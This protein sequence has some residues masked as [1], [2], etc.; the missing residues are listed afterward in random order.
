[1]SAPTDRVPRIHDAL[2][3]APD[4][5][6][7]RVLDPSGNEAGWLGDVGRWLVLRLD[8]V[9]SM[10]SLR[11]EFEEAFGEPLGEG[12]LEAILERLEAHGLL[13]TNERALWALRYLAEKGLQYR[14]VERERR[15]DGSRQETRRAGP[16]ERAEAWDH[17]V[18]LVNEAYLERALGVFRELA[19]QDPSDLR[20]Q[21]MV[22]HLEF[23]LAQESS[24]HL[25]TDRR[26]DDWEAFDQALRDMLESGRCPRCH[27]TLIIELGRTNHCGFCGGSFTSFVLQQAERRS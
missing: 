11:G 3:I 7:W 9:R 4:G 16:D 12:I 26:D 27:E 2:E 19:A 24:P 1:M 18:Y 8:G 17:G 25:N 23:L 13:N 5:D 6:T 15:T 20:V 22:R 21:G 14:S 10:A